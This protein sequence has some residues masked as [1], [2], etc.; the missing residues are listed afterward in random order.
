[1]LN[2]SLFKQN[3]SLEKK[4][5]RAAVDPRIPLCSPDC[6][7]N[8]KVRDLLDKPDPMDKMPSFQIQS[9]AKSSVTKYLE[10]MMVNYNG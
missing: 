8:R 4:K 3:N 7:K 5:I 6:T 2:S 9:Q 10:I 1:M